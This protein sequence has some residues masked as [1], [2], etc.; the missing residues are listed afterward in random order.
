MYP[1]GM[2]NVFLWCRWMYRLLYVLIFHP[3][4]WTIYSK[5]LPLLGRASIL[6]ALKRLTVI[7]RENNFTTEILCHV[8][9]HKQQQGEKSTIIL[10]HDWAKRELPGLHNALL[11][12]QLQRNKESPCLVGFVSLISLSHPFNIL[13]FLNMFRYPEALSSPCRTQNKMLKNSM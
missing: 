7:F 3:N 1:M 13:T 6:T 9:P 8:S 4:E 12:K 2:W 10:K 11:A 5:L